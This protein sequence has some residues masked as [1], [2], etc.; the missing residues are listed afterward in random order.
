MSP[1]KKEKK[2]TKSTNLIFALCTLHH[3]G[4][5]YQLRFCKRTEERISGRREIPLGDC[6]VQEQP[7]TNVKDQKGNK[8]EGKMGGTLVASEGQFG[9][10][11]KT[12][13]LGRRVFDFKLLRRVTG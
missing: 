3:Q 13:V 8:F 1:Q 11:I 9:T 5:N 6:S 2:T 4:T 12:R 10:E 7:L